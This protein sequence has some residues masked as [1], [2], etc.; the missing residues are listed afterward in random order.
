M[1]AAIILIIGLILLVFVHELGHFLAAK[2]AG[3]KVEEFGFGFPPRIKGW[4]YGE[5]LYSINWLPLGGFVRIHGENKHRSEEL[6]RETGVLIE[7]KRAFFAQSFWRRFVVIA[8]G[9]SINFIAGW[10]LLSLVYMVGARQAVVITEVQSG[11]PAESVQLQSGDELIGFTTAE[12][13]IEFT[14]T[15]QGKQVSIRIVR[16]GEELTVTPL[17]R[18]ASPESA[19]LGA[20]ISPVGFASLSFFSA[21]K[22]GLVDSVMAVAEIFRAFGS[23]IGKLFS[24]ASVPENIVGPVGIFGIAGDLGKLGFVYILQLVAMISL[25][26]AALNAIPFPAL[27]GGRILFM[28]IEKLKGSPLHPVREMWTNAISFGFLI[29][30]MLIITGRD[31]IRLF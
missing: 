8:A 4:Q 21:L 18:R 7:A 25:N 17:L 29:L 10:L 20:A 22:K 2:Q 19:P 30:L 11:S 15:E 26:L 27:D 31:I 3:I 6:A 12:E 14:K 23:L 1:F 28:V 16:S 24:S 9:I 13:F 5:T